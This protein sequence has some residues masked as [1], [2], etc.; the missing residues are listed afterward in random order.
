VIDDNCGDSQVREQIWRLITKEKLTELIEKVETLA[1]PPEDNYY[2]ELLTKWRSIRIF[3]PHLL[4]VIE[5]VGVIRL[6]NYYKDKL[7]KQ[8]VLMSVG[9]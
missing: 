1:R 9:L 2:Q 8:P 5:F 3:L 6:L 4:R 7:G